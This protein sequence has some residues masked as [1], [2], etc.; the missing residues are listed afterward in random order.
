MFPGR[1]G[2]RMPDAV[3][4][5]SDPYDFAREMVAA[6]F[7]API[8]EPVTFD[9]EFEVAALDDPDTLFGM[10]PD[11]TALDK[12]DKAAVVA[13][14]RRMAGDQPILRIPSTALIGVARR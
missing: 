4:A 14:V 11:W 13:E 8:I 1:E 2:V 6:G 7:T 9:Y 5:L 3:A 10:S 12:P